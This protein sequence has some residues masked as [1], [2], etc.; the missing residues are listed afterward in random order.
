M[1]EGMIGHNIV[2]DDH[3]AGKLDRDSCAESCFR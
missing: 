1:W 3:K 2:N